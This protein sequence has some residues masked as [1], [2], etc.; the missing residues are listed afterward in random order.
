MRLPRL[1][2][3][4]VAVVQRPA[5]EEVQQWRQAQAQVPEDPPQAL[6]P[7]ARTRHQCLLPQLLE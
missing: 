3:M 2:Q 4:R 7:A 5:K 6:L 1:E